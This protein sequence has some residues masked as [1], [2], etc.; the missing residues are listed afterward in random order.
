VEDRD[1]SV[2]Q[3]NALIRAFH[4]LTAPIA[5]K[6]GLHVEL[7]TP[8]AR[9][10]DWM[11]TE[12]AKKLRLF[13]NNANK[14]TGTGHPMDL[15]RW[16]AFLVAAHGEGAEIDSEDLEHWLTEQ[17]WQPD[18]AHDLALQYEFGR[19]LLEYVDPVPPVSG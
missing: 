4:R 1:L 12:A 10:K 8:V 3:C 6:L 19:V 11:S 13:S 17:G 2:L 9:L 14:N 16:M 5:E 18:I 7:T 15:Q